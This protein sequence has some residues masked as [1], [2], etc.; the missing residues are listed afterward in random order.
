M[1][2][3]ATGDGAGHRS[4]EEI[5]CAVEQTREELSDTVTELRARLRRIAGRLGLIAGAV[6][7]L[8]AGWKAA[9]RRR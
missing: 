2:K 5:A 7:V 4:T 3:G 8:V 9:R 1:G 6:V